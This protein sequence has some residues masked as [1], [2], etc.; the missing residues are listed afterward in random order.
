MTN[1]KHQ[2]RF[3]SISGL[4]YCPLVTF[5]SHL[6][7][8]SFLFFGIN[9]TEPEGIKSFGKRVD[10]VFF[11]INSCHRRKKLTGEN[12]IHCSGCQGGSSQL[13]LILD[14]GETVPS[15]QTAET[16]GNDF[17][18]ENPFYTEGRTRNFIEPTP[19]LT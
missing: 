13:P 14:T 2:N 17:R 9:Q 3:K 12:I 8:S 7:Y 4:S 18:T 16:G 6:G 1:G 11:A 19:Q 10:R 5:N 15:I